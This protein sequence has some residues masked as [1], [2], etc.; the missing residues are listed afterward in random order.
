[1]T[2]TGSFLLKFTGFN[3]GDH[4]VIALMLWKHLSSSGVHWKVQLFCTDP[5]NGVVYT[6]ISG[7]YSARSWQD[8]CQSSI[9][10]NLKTWKETA[11]QIDCNYCHLLEVKQAQ[12][13]HPS[14]HLTPL[15]TC[16]SPIAITPVTPSAPPGSA[17]PMDIDSNH[18]VL[19]LGH[20]TTIISRDTLLLIALNLAENDF[21]P[22]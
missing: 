2:Y 21:V 7:I 4:I 13:P 12:A 20:A 18:H 19:K 9:P 6:I 14:G 5:D 10:S 15:Q 22:I 1:M 16:S 8:P 3:I 11:C 17:T